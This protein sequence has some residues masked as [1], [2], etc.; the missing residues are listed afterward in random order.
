MSLLSTGMFS[1]S[2][3]EKLSLERDISRTLA[4]CQRLLNGDDLAE[5]SASAQPAAAVTPTTPGQQ[6]QSPQQQPPRPQLSTADYAEGLRLVRD[7]RL[8]IDD[9]DAVYGCDDG[10]GG[11][12]DGGKYRYQQYAELGHPRL[13][14]CHFLQGRCLGG[15]G[16][17]AEA[18]DAFEAARDLALRQAKPAVARVAAERAAAADRRVREQRRGAGVWEA[19]AYDA[20]AA[21]GGRRWYRSLFDS[22]GRDELLRKLGARYELWDPEGPLTVRYVKRSRPVIV[23][24]DPVVGPSCCPVM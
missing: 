17:H 6:P 3:D 9:A 11:G 18:R 19:H 7:A 15:L 24:G 4:A 16:R 8:L 22:D 13:A 10:C 1:L 12:S 14:H 21:A 23:H 5:P 20:A 2:R